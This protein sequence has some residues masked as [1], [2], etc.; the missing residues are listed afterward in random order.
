VSYL[1]K[2]SE[3]NSPLARI[4]IE[5]GAI[6]F[7]KTNIPLTLMTAKALNDMSAHTLNA[8]NTAPTAGDSNGEEGALV[9]F[10]GSSRVLES[11]WCRYPPSLLLRSE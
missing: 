9:A 5:Q 1:N 4:L 2:Y 11:I 8:H 10:R 7:V 6:L 3:I